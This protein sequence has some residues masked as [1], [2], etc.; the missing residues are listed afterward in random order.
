MLESWIP[1]IILFFREL[2]IPAALMVLIIAIFVLVYK[3]Y[4][5]L[6]KIEEDLRFRR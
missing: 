3:S 5:L 1:T 2:L 6:K 4:K